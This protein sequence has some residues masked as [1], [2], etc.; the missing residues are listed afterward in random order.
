MATDAELAF[1]DQAGSFY[2]REYS[3]PPVTGRLL[4]YLIVCDP[5]QQTINELA[6]ALLAS[7]SAITG[8]VRQLES[9]QAVRRTRAAGDRLDRVSLNPAAGLQPRGFSPAPYQEQ[10]ALAREALALLAGAPAERRA[11]LEDAAAFYDFLAQRLPE[12]LDEW[13]QQRAA[14]P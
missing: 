14:L 4:G 3:F 9:F 2:A 12:V 8:A 5:P 1:A 10:A 13:H 7:R 6:E 11:V